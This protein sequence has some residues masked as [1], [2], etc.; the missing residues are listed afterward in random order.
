MFYVLSESRNC[1]WSFWSRSRQCASGEILVQVNFSWNWYCVNNTALGCLAAADSA[2][3]EKIILQHTFRRIIPISVLSLYF[4]FG[5]SYKITKNKYQVFDKKNHF[6][7]CA[8]KINNKTYLLSNSFLAAAIT[9]QL[10]FLLFKT[11]RQNIQGYLKKIKITNFP[12]Q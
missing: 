8:L 12:Y 6:S 10:N 2:L 1:R 9:C 4:F 7:H 11:F 3:W 5:Q